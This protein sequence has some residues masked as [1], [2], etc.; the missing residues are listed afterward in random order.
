MISLTTFSD[1]EGDITSDPS[2]RTD[3]DTTAWLYDEATGLELKKTYADGS[4]TSK[5][6][7]KFNRLETLTKA[8]GIVTTYA[9]APLTGELISVSHSDDTP[10]WKFTY[11]H[12]GQMTY[13]R[14]ASG[15]RECSYDVYGNM[16]QDTSFGTVESSLQEEYD[17][18]GRSAGCRLMLGTRTVQHSHLDYDSKGGMIGIN[19]EGLKSPFTWEY[20]QT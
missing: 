5:T 7:D 9:Y 10:G 17:P 1:G 18:F 14:D 13:V 4:F 2:N 15:I 6:Y 20:D 16:I 3:G 11:N 19:L 12:I 8:R